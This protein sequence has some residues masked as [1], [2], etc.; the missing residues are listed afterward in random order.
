MP[1]HVVRT[2]L[3]GIFAVILTLLATGVTP[4]QGSA[5]VVNPP[6]QW[7]GVSLAGADFGAGE[8]WIGG[9][10]IYPRQA[11]LEYFKAKGMTTIRLPFRWERIQPVLNGP[12]STT[13]L[14]EI[15][16]VVTN[17]NA[18]GMN[19]ILDVHNYARWL[20]DTDPDLYEDDTNML[21]GDPAPPLR[22][23]W[24]RLANEFKAQGPMVQ[25]AL[26][27]E[28]QDYRTGAWV[29]ALN[30]VIA[31]VRG[32]GATNLILVPGMGYTGMHSWFDTWYDAG[33]NPVSNANAMWANPAAAG[34]IVDSAN[35][36]AYEV[37]QYVDQGFEGSGT[38]I[39][40]APTK[41]VQMTDWLR[42]RG[43][44]AFLAETAIPQPANPNA[45]TA[46]DIA[47]A[48]SLRT[49]LDYIE[50][51]GD[52]WR[53]WSYWAAGQWW[54]PGTTLQPVPNTCTTACGDS[55]QM[56]NIE[57]YL[58]PPTP[59]TTGG[60]QGR[61]PGGGG[62]F[63]SPIITS[64]GN[65]IV[66]SDL[67]GAFI[68]KNAGVS[69]TQIGLGAGLSA[70][71]VASMASTTSGKL[72]I[73]VDGGLYTGA[74]A[75]TGFV[76]TYATN[77]VSAIGVAANQ[78]TI[79]AAVHNDWAS[80]NPTIIKSTNSGLTWAAT[81]SNLP[82]TLRITGLRT[83]PTNSNT[84]WAISGKARAATGP[85]QAFRSTNGGVTWTRNDP[86]QGDLIDVAYAEAATTPDLMYATAI[87]S[88][89]GATFKSTNGGTTW[90]TISTATAKPS[91]II[92]ADKL[93]PAHVRIVDLDQRAG[94]ATYLWE[95][96]NSGSTWTK[97]TL[98]VAGGWSQ[99]DE[100]W[101]MGYSYQGL[102]QTLGYRPA[103]PN[104]VLWSNN[105]FVYRSLDGAKTWSDPMSELVSTRWRSRGITNNVPYVVE[106][107]L[108]DP[109]LVYAGYADLG[110]W[111]SNDGGVSWKTLNS[112]ALSH[113]WAGKGGNT[114][115]VVADPTQANVVWAQLGGNLEN[116]VSATSCAEPLHLVKSTN[117]G[118]TWTE[119][120]A[121]LPTPLKRVSGLTVA[122]DSAP[123]ARWLY[124]VAN[125][126][127]YLSKDGGPTWER[128]VDCP[129]NDCSAVTYTANNGVLALSPSGIW[130]SW[131]GGVAGSWQLL[132]LPVAMTSGW[133]SGQHWLFNK[134]T[135]VGPV[136][137]TA[138]A[139]QLWVAVTG[140]GK[141]IYHSADYGFSWT[142][143][144]ADAYARSV[145]YDATSNAVYYGSSSKLT[146]D[147]YATGSNGV[148]F[149]VDG[150]TNWTALNS[151]L[152]FP[153]AT[154]LAL[155]AAGSGWATS[156]GQGVVRWVP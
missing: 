61:N 155:G 83:H 109:N 123:A 127:V 124:V 113:L 5:A 121:G 131:Q 79:Y 75:G 118:D 22:D 135:F 67:G 9:E 114:M 51:N 63:N 3:T 42:A 28:P 4:N 92:L 148:M 133:T 77:Y 27:N 91:G 8:K 146:G 15:S 57:S 110:L 89:A 18:L 56:N 100:D 16:S 53:G 50:A 96:A 84:V 82:A 32:T 144:R 71:H 98:S 46:A 47:C 41:V 95:S 120:T 80:L 117:Q 21:V 38:D 119:L 102:A 70:T 111:R 115:T 64:E 58:Q 130:R 87:V 125:G 66:G 141:G 12:L 17:A 26:M 140:A 151:G 60:W 104:T 108:A 101:G 156:P 23:L 34:S 45:L 73:G 6:V 134:A 29:T 65:W 139:G 147:P 11:E 36:F 85:K 126:D 35:N 74:T 94:K 20:A 19:V 88:G 72:L 90:A 103:T 128:V 142:L 138:K 150:I 31:G 152:G 149:S 97:T 43:R 154:S 14:A 122:P 68:S 52:V 69:W 105:L 116:C 129:N 48:Q 59:P 33:P 13:E 153:F 106:P 99:V 136:E 40:V 39:C 143:V 30:S 25:F 2:V 145:A 55:Y 78:T 49:L 137:L 86:L 62:A 132:T 107:S 112:L 10:W 37:H 93:T 54:S 24:V 1:R 44:T 81:G 76:K 7:R